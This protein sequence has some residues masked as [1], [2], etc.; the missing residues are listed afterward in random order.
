MIYGE[1][2]ILQRKDIHVSFK[3]LG[4]SYAEIGKKKRDKNLDEERLNG[5]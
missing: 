4:R 1:K 3:E 2:I 5:F